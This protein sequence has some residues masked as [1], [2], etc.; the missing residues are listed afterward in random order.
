MRESTEVRTV[1]QVPVDK[2]FILTDIISAKIT[3]NHGCQLFQILNSNETR[4]KLRF[5][6]A[7][8]ENPKSL[9]LG[10]GI[11]FAPGSNLAIQTLGCKAAILISGYY[12]Q[13]VISLD[14]TQ[15]D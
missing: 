4:I 9:H 13:N 5:E 6:F 12:I 8:D 7:V 10:S 2:T 1:L 14:P 15:E 11:P 3:N